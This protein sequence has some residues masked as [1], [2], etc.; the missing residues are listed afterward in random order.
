VKV[1]QVKVNDAVWRKIKT[2]LRV[3]DE[4]DLQVGILGDAGRTIHEGS[5]LTVI[6][7]GA[8]HEYGT[9]DGRVPERSWLRRTFEEK[10]DELKQTQL[11]VMKKFFDGQFDAMKVLGV[12][13]LWASTEVKKTIT[14]GPHIPPPLKEATIAAKGSDRPLV[15]TGQMVDAISWE[16]KKKV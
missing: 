13:G 5:D 2:G 4:R 16:V 15:D 6:E 10:E 7:I 12:M 11:K 3:L 9:E 14:V 1:G 8:V